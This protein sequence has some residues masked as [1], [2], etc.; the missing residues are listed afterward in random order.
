MFRG[1]AH[2]VATALLL[3][4]TMGWAKPAAL[5]TEIYGL[6]LGA[7]L[8]QVKQYLAKTRWKSTD[9]RIRAVLGNLLSVM[10]ANLIR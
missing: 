9:T 8:A 10:G 1:V 7:T 2:L 6:K 5:P 3:A 4:S